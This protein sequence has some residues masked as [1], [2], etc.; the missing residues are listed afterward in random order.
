MENSAFQ[1]NANVQANQ[2][3]AH[4]TCVLHVGGNGRFNKKTT[5]KF[6]HMCGAIRA[7]C[8][9]LT[10]FRDIN[11]EKHRLWETSAFRDGVFEGKRGSEM[12]LPMAA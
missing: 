7:P 5:T 3:A 2:R 4:R 8:F 6:D 1:P 12:P 11:H 9:Q 10:Y